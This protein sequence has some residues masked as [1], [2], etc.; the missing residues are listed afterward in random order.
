MGFPEIKWK[1]EKCRLL[2]DGQ[3]PNI[4]LTCFHLLVVVLDRLGVD[5][6][7]PADDLVLVLVEEIDQVQ[8]STA[9]T[10]RQQGQQETGESGHDA[11][12]VTPVTGRF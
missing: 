1:I 12:Q 2:F 11:L 5:P 8:H 10:E 4:F 3:S 6:L 9:T 7:A